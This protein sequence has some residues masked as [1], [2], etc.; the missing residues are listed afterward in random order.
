MMAE[1][2]VTV[3]VTWNVD[4]IDALRDRFR[5]CGVLFRLGRRACHDVVCVTLP[6]ATLAEQSSLLDE[7]YGLSNHLS[8]ILEQAAN[9]LK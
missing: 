7:V 8:G 9:A 3:F 1:K 5:G 4:Q 2:P 6:R